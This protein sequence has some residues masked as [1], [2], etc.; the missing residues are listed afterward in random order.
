MNIRWFLFLCHN[1]CLDFIVLAF[2]PCV[3]HVRS[4]GRPHFL[5]SRRLFICLSCFLLC[6]GRTAADCTAVEN[7]GGGLRCHDLRRS[8]NNL[9][10]STSNYLTNSGFWYLFLMFICVDAFYLRKPGKIPYELRCHDLRRSTN[11][12]GRS[13]SNF[14]ANSGFWCLFLMF[15]CADAFYLRKP[16][17][18]SYVLFS[19]CACLRE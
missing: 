15:I 12:L 14:L 8:T 5:C 4:A 16:G 9:H 17:K 3:T 18:I 10:R 6:L 19:T 11:N 2:R 1:S 7:H 13:T